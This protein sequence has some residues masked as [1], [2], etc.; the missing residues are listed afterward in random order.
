MIYKYKQLELEYTEEDL[1]YIED[2][3]K[4]LEKYYDLILSFFNLKKLNR[5]IKMKFWNNTTGFRRFLAELN[6]KKTDL[7]EVGRTTSNAKSSRIDILSYKEFI[8]CQGHENQT[9]QDLIKVCIHELV[10]FVQ[11]DYNNHTYIMT[12]LSE[13]LAT[14]L[15]GQYENKEVYFNTTLDEII[16]GKSNYCNYY[17]MGKYLLEEYNKEY[18][19]KLVRDNELVKKET[20]RI[21]KETFKYLDKIYNKE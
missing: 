4:E 5:N 18:I 9:I 17:L 1:V 7:W 14:N 6:T 3:K 8:K 2:F 13:A 12:W 16:R 11:F 21:F 20:P 15:S 19:L 10:H